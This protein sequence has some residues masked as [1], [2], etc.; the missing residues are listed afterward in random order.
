M[1]LVNK[2]FYIYAP[3]L[4]V[5][6]VIRMQVVFYSSVG[7]FTWE[8]TQSIKEPPQP[9]PPPLPPPSHL[10]STGAARMLGQIKF[11]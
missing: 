5:W 3:V 4:D 6:W 9:P 8:Q 11:H 7:D 2:I 10:P 1:H